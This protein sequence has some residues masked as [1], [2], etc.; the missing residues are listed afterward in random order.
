MH[1]LELVI[2]TVEIVFKKVYI[3]YMD[4]QKQQTI[5]KTI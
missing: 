3:V 2:T 1:V 5:N 4:K